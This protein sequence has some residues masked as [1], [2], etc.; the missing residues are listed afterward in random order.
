AERGILVPVRFEHASL[1]IDVRTFHT[2]D[3]DGVAGD[4]SSPQLQEVLRALEAMIAGSGVAAATPRAKAA[5]P[6]GP[7]AHARVSI[8]VLPFVNMSGDAEQEYFS[9]GI[10]EDIITD[11][12]KVSALAVT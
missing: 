12:S 11:L 6:S 2:T 1:P 5:S 9:D 4:V 7:P 10:T 8:C 3:L